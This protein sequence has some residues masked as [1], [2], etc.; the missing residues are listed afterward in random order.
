MYN[1]PTGMLSQ[2]FIDQLQNSPHGTTWYNIGQLNML[3][4][5]TENSPSNKEITP[6]QLGVE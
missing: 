6:W 1:D 5:S 4:L 2:S 3:R